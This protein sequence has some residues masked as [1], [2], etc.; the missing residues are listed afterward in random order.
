M[1]VAFE[2]IDGAGK[3]TTA[4]LVVPRLAS[5]GFRVLGAEKRSP[6]VRTEFAA[7]HLGVLA[8]RLWGVPHDDRLKSLGSLH[9]IYLNAAYFAGVHH[10]LSRD[11]SGLDVVVFDSWINKFV[12]R[13]ATNGEFTLP[14]II[15][16]L[17]A[18]PRPD[19]VF[20]LDV[21]PKVAAGRKP[22]ATVLERRPLGGRDEDFVAYQ[23][24]IR[25]SLLSLADEFGW[26]MIH[27]EDRSAAQVADA[28]VDVIAASLR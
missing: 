3:T 10:C 22:A 9:W 11:S 13:A 8:D 17:A 20:M 16:V 27:A 18:L 24:V 15:E 28:V 25:S 23:S 4:A 12:T 6:G 5:L 7:E 2:G 14:E 1:L 21:S 19:L 26:T